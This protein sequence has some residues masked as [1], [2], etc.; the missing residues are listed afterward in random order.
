MGRGSRERKRVPAR[1]TRAAEPGAGGARESPAASGTGRDGA[2]LGGAGRQRSRGARAP[3]CAQRPGLPGGSRMR[4]RPLRAAGV[5]FGFGA[6]F[7]LVRR[8][9]RCFRLAVA[10]V[11]ARRCA[12]VGM[13]VQ[14][15][16]NNQQKQTKSSRRRAAG[17][18]EAAR[19]PCSPGARGRRPPRA[20]LGNRPCPRS[21]GAWLTL[22]RHREKRDAQIS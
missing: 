10:L 6:S 21:A 7:S 1:G 5:F 11:P 4:G 16:K 3:G 20:V 15:K 12:A 14:K 9:L 13:E 19:T 22:G 17:A 18:W 2:G 8:F